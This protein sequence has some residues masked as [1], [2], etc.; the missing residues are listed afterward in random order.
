M[1]P[2][3]EVET[4]FRL[5]E[6][7]AGIFINRNIGAEQ[8]DLLRDL[9]KQAPGYQLQLGHDVYRQPDAIAV[10]LADLAI[11]VTGKN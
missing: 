11:E 3:G 5:I 1:K 9:V 6:Q 2:L 10:L 7:S 4:L 8:L